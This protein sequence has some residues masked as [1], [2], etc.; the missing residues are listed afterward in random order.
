MVQVS[1]ERCS[2]EETDNGVW[3]EGRSAAEVIAAW[4]RRHVPDETLAT[5]PLE[6]AVHGAYELFGEVGYQVAWADLS[7]ER[8]AYFILAFAKSVGINGAPDCEDEAEEDRVWMEATERVAR[9]THV[10]LVRSPAHPRYPKR[11]AGGWRLT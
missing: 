6:D 2:G 7:A 3:M 5:C 4:N 1:C 9:A 11:G 8:R 10:V